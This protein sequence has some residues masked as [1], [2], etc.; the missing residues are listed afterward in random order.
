VSWVQALDQLSTWWHLHRRHSVRNTIRS[1]S[2]QKQIQLVPRPVTSLGHLG[3]GAKS[4]LRVCPTHFS[5]GGE[6]ILGV[7]LCAPIYGPV[8][9]ILL[10]HAV[11]NKAMKLLNCLS[12]Q[13]DLPISYNVWRSELRMINICFHELTTGNQCL[14]KKEPQLGTSFSFS[15]V[16]AILAYISQLGTTQKKLNIF[17]AFFTIHVFVRLQAN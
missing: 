12:F 2:P 3:G 9:S 13:W 1:T 10:K 11:H 15:R 6:K 8:S 16:T 5:R 14:G 17:S 4:F 7:G